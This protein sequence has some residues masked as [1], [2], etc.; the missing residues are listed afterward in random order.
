M[1][2]LRR[3]LS[4]IVMIVLV[5]GL[6]GCAKTPVDTTP[7]TTAPAEIPFTPVAYDPSEDAPLLPRDIYS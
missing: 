2:Q 1:K 7:S 3:V 4:A 6:F 5:L